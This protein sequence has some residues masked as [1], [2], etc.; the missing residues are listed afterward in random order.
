[1]P[2]LHRWL[3]RL[4]LVVVVLVAAFWGMRLFIPQLDEGW[5]VSRNERLVASLPTYPGARSYHLE[6][7]ADWGD[8]DSVISLFGVLPPPRGYRTS[9]GFVS[10]PGVTTTEV[11]D[12]YARALTD[13]GWA[14]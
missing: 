3:R 12:F 2:A 10:P 9:T 1:M 8:A 4:L 13:K 7:H 14:V 5:Y 11:F 6:S